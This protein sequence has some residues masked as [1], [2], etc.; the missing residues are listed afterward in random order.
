MEAGQVSAFF[1]DESHLHWHEAC[2]YGWGRRDRRLEVA[3]E[4]GLQ[5][6]TYY[7]ALD[8]G[9]GTFLMQAY[10]KANAHHTVDFIRYLQQRRPG[11]KLLIFW[12]GVS[13]H[14]QQAMRTFLE[15]IQA[16][17]P[18]DEWKIDCTR[19]APYT[20]QEN[21]VEDLWLKGKTFVRTHALW[22]TCFEQIKDLFVK[23]IRRKKYCHFPKLQQYRISLK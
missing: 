2:G 17:L 19:L 21:P 6:Q 13:Y 15:T 9:K 22:T 23:G 14:H 5:R 8:I 20:P 10:P 7:G 1:I 16:D 4:N 12:D 18:P 3:I 11:Q